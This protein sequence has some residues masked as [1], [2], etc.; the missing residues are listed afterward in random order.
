MENIID[1]DIGLSYRPSS[2]CSLVDWY[3][4]VNLIPAV[5]DYEFGYITG[6]K[7]VLQN[8]KWD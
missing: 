5:R 8:Q 3:G 7:T 6:R 2:L 1:S 4:G